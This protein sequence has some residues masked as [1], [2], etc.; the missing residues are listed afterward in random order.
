MRRLALAPLVVVAIQALVLPAHAADPLRKYQYGFVR[1]GAERAW[2][3]AR[4]AGVAIAIIDTGID[5]QHEDLRPRL[6]QG[7]D[8][9]SNDDIPQDENGHGTHVAGIAA[10]ASGNGIGI[11]GVAPDAQIMPLRVLDQKGTGLESSVASA[12]NW[13][14]LR[15]NS[16]GM[17]LVLNMS[18][19]DLE[20]RGTVT[21]RRIQDAVRQ[22]WFA[23][24]VIVA[25]VGNE[26]LPFGNYPAAGPNILAVGATNEND[27]RAGFSNKGA[28]VVAP[29]DRI[30]S[31]YWDGQTPNDHTVYASGSGTSMAAPFVAGVAALLL[32]T[33]LNNQQTVD[34][35]AQTADDLGAPG[36]DDEFGYGM[37][38]A[39]RALNLPDGAGAARPAPLVPAQVPGAAGN[40]FEPI[41]QTPGPLAAASSPDQ[42]AAPPSKAVPATV[43]A[44]LCAIAYAAARISQGWRAERER[45]SPWQF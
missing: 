5:L 8:F 43:A 29:G 7:R 9:V 37:V 35:I 32:S 12:I 19:T 39:P 44:L 15:A 17:R 10:A 28:T 16:L 4:G 34:R 40:K 36:R 25:A 33:G 14:L 3:R 13:A 21:S 38:N 42:P 41:E 2:V 1:V 24:A 18:F 20:Y 45:A 26:S 11:D 31:T 23:G 30:V 22:A 27:R 6:M